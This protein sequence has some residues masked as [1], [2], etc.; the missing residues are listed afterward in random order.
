[1]NELLEKFHVV[2][3]QEEQIKQERLNLEKQ[4]LVKVNNQ[5]LECAKTVSTNH[6]KVSVTNKLNRKLDHDK[7][8]EISED[9]PEALK[10]VK[11]KPEIDLKK[12]R[13]LE[14]I[15]PKIISECI[16]TKPYKPSITI[17]EIM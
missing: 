16:T 14:A 7:Y 8:L 5:K 3:L 4:I 15:D 11:Y 1:M 12:L 2:K 13:S 17:K 6:F 9:L 10:F